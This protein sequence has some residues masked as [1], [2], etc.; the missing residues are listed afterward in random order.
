MVHLARREFITLLGGAAAAWPLAARAQQS[1]RIRRVGV[2]TALAESDPEVMAWLK[3]FQEEL[4]RLG[5]EQGRNIRIEH[6]SAGNDQHRLRTGAAE[7]V[8]MT[9]DVLFAN[10]TPALVALNR[11]TR[12]L[13]IVF[14]QVSDPVKLGFVTNLARPSDRR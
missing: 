12:S 9:P 7:L 13:P 6:R 4:Q 10:A 11:E 1:Q 2:L 14:V 3:A 8:G 5:W